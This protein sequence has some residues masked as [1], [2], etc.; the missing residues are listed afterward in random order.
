MEELDPGFFVYC[1]ATR[2][3]YPIS[4]ST[5]LRRKVHVLGIS[6]FF[7]SSPQSAIAIGK[8]P[9]NGNSQNGTNQHQSNQ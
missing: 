5:A 8:A 3:V 6:I 7:G 1:P 2:H 4:M 9:K